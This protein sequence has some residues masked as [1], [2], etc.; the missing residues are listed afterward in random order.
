MDDARATTHG[1]ATANGRFQTSE[2]QEP[3]R[4]RFQAQEQDSR[5]ARHI[6]ASGF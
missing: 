1:A 2:K 6:L 3:A 5:A 4:P